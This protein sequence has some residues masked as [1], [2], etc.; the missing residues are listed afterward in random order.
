MNSYN[1][2]NVDYLTNV[3][4]NIYKN[5]S[6]EDQIYLSDKINA[7]YRSFNN[8]SIV[9]NYE[10]KPNVEEQKRLD[11]LI[12]YLGPDYKDILLNYPDVGCTILSEF[13]TPQQNNM[14]ISIYK[15]LKLYFYNI[16]L[17]IYTNYPKSIM[18][19]ID[20]EISLTEFLKYFKDTSI[21]EKDIINKYYIGLIN[22]DNITKSYFTSIEYNM[23]NTTIETKELKIEKLLGK[24]Y[25]NKIP[26]ICLK[27][28]FNNGREIYPYK[29]ITS[30]LILKQTLVTIIIKGTP[31]TTIIDSS[32]INF[33]TTHIIS[34]INNEY[35]AC[36]ICNK[37]NAID[38]SSIN[39]GI[40]YFTDIK[41]NMKADSN[42]EK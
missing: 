21:I 22:L 13:I 7:L 10:Y 16:T 27:E 20:I 26:D 23:V 4:Y 29:I 14:N 28:Y 3:L 38:I 6:E 35:Y 33:D 8:Q 25:E 19:C 42:N 32:E 31:I 30:N 2:Q 24:N 12:T 9:M 15:V 11:L 37:Q 18:D 36:F 17:R 41:Y 1:R 5:S 34:M 39:E 40:I